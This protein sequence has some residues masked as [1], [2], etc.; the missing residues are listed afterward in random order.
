[1]RERYTDRQKDRGEEIGTS[2]RRPA[3]L[4]I[5]YVWRRER[6]ESI[7]TISSS[8][9]SSCVYR[10]VGALSVTFLLSCLSLPIISRGSYLSIRVHTLE[11]MMRVPKGRCCE[12]VWSRDMDGNRKVPASAIEKKK[13]RQREGGGEPHVIPRFRQQELWEEEWEEQEERKNERDDDV[14]LFPMCEMKEG[15]ERRFC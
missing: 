7:L 4:W 1:M 6:T 8:F 3:N 14:H 12:M 15:G 10:L 9:L 11:T 2:N 5:H 13:K